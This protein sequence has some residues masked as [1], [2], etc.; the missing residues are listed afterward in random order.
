LKRLLGPEDL[1]AITGDKRALFIFDADW[2]PGSHEIL[3][4]TER[5]I[6]GPSGSVPLFD[7]YSLDMTGQVNR[8][9]K[10]G[11][12]GKFSISP[13]GAH[14]ALTT[15]SRIS[16][17]DLKTNKQKILLEFK[18][19]L[20][21]SEI[22]FIARVAWDPQG[23][24][25]ATSIPPEKMRYSDYAGEPVQVWRLFVNG[26]AELITEF[27]PYFPNP[28]ASFSPNLQY[29][30]YLNNT[31]SGK[32]GTLTLHIISSASEIS[33]M[34]CTMELPTWTPDSEQFYHTVDGLWQLGS[35]TSNTYQPIDFLNVPTE[36]H[37]HIH[38]QLMWINDEYF[39]L[40]RR[41]VDACTLTIASFRGIVTEIAR[42]AP[43]NCP[44]GIAFSVPK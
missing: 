6:D 33:L 7:L 1:V 4:N 25:M 41:S 22:M 21:P 13:T 30:L 31:C 8:L 12:G 2:I 10:A 37:V 17:L 23:R 42:T 34:N 44:R 38:P 19:L 3:F 26:Q 14:V 16:V 39:L 35:I 43:D 29:F 24:F 32:W 40:I 36:P 20:I 9:A 28:Q 18:P 27:Q 15:N 5:V 11:S